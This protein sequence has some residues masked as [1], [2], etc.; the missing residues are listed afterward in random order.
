MACSLPH[1]IDEVK[2]IVHKQIKEDNVRQQ[3]IINLAV[4][5]ENASDTKD[6]TR[7]AYDECDDI[8]QEK[9]YMIDTLL[10]EESWKVYEIHNALIRNA[11]KMQDEINTKNTRSNQY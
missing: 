7:K 9:R 1:I 5:F 2:A 3:A 8:P 10:K 11:T 4:Q 6:D